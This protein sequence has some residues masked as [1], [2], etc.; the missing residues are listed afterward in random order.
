MEML[1]PF[2]WKNEEQSSFLENILYV[3]IEHLI[4]QLSVK[5]ELFL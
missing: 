1:V 3:T 5:L 2:G 4:L